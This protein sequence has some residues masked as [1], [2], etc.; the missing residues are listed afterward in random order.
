MSVVSCC[1]RWDVD[2]G[3]QVPRCAQS[4]TA[5]CTAAGQLIDDA[6]SQEEGQRAS[7]ASEK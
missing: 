4:G 5:N 2:V 3:G 7:E 1:A 6:S